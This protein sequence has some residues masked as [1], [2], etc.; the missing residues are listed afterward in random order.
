MLALVLLGAVSLPFLGDDIFVLTV[1]KLDA[2]MLGHLGCATQRFWRASVP[3]QRARG[4]RWATSPP[5]APSG[6][7]PPAR[8]RYF[9]SSTKSAGCCCDL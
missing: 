2:H 8:A 6:A 1:A 7:W 4:A 9:S 5:G 3:N